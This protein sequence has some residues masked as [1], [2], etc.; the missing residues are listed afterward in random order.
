MWKL[1]TEFGTLTLD[2]ESKTDFETR[3]GPIEKLFS[4]FSPVTLK[5]LEEK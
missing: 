4:E 2:D 5:P 1:E 3:F